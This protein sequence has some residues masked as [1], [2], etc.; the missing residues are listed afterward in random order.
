MQDTKGK[1]VAGLFSESSL[2]QSP[3]QTLSE[4]TGT[5]G[6]ARYNRH[7]SE[8]ETLFPT[9]EHPHSQQTPF[10]LRN[11]LSYVLPRSGSTL[12]ALQ[13]I[14]GKTVPLSEYK[15]KVALVVNVASQW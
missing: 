13:D 9:A 1:T 6:T 5:A 10:L 2:Q 3:Q 14:K 4:K 8:L 7:S 12:R 11:F 15:G